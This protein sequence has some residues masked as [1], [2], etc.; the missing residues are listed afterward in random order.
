[1]ATGDLTLDAHVGVELDGFALDVRLTV[2]AGATVAVLGPNGAGKTTLLNALAGLVPLTAGRVQLG[3]DVLEDAAT[4]VYTRPEGR[5]IGVVFQDYLLF[6][7]L[8]ALDNVAFPLRA[9]GQSRAAARQH[10]A[11]WLDRVGLAERARARPAALS[12]GQAQRTAL[13]RAL[14]TEPAV[15][16]LDEPLA[17][18]D[19]ATRSEV[20]RDLRVALDA[21]A[22]VRIV[23]THDPL[24]AAALAERL[25]VIED[26]RVVQAGTAAELAAHPRSA[27][28]AELAGTNLFAGVATG[29]VVTLDGGGSLTVGGQANGPVFAVAHP[30]TV[31]LSPH[32]PESSAR[33]AWQATVD[34][35]D[36][37]GDRFRVRLGGRTPVVAEITE[38]AA[39]ELGVTA[40]VELW[41]S[42]K[43][44]EI[45]VY[46]R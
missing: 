46:A 7:H 16:L 1:M 23:V 39:T 19:V 40:G 10:A 8:S 18:L 9:R 11:A 2:A 33:N 36:R 6:P 12:G 32:R 28:V 24:E 34:G 3:D 27:F 20:R 25:I 31:A 43:A 5:P 37:L 4:G 15:L 22:G 38:A 13:A 45:D 26:G 17:A 41:A 29:H 44:S 42:I 14:I 30:R 21:F 35:V